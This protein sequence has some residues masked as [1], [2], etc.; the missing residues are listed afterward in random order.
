MYKLIDYKLVL[1]SI[2]YMG[3]LNVSE[4]S[5]GI[6]QSKQTQKGFVQAWISTRGSPS[7]LTLK[8]GYKDQTWGTRRNSFIKRH[9]K[10]IKL[11][12]EPLFINGNPSRRHLSLIAW[13]Y[14]PNK[15]RLKAWAD[16][17]PSPYMGLYK[18]FIG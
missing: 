3:Q 1:S 11:N 16:K 15:R 14:T 9:M 17:Q 6:K 7:I 13:G 4:V 8:N 10:Q 2:P 18:M 5:R 12:N